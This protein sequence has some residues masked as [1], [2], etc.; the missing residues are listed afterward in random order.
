MRFTTT[1][2]VCI[3]ALLVASGA[4]AQAASAE[5]SYV[6]SAQ[7]IN[8]AE[9]ALGQ[10][11]QKQGASDEVK[12]M[13]RAMVERH[14]ALRAELA[15]LARA[16]GIETADHPSTEDQQAHDRLAGLSGRSFDEAFEHAVA[17]AHTRELA[18][19]RGALEH[20]GDAGLRSYAQSRVRALEAS[21]AHAKDEW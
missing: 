21:T 5:R 4:R 18:L 20:S 10:L 17:D 1:T 13:A 19:H 11:A 2:R 7:T 16:R 14:S 9:L 15:D 6:Q 3:A 8:L 12:Q